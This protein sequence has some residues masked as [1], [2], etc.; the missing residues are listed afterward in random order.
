MPEFNQI[1][2]DLENKIKELE[3]SIQELKDNFEN[4]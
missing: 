3:K 4:Q 2:K 1:T